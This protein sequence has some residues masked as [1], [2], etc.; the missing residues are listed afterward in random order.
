MSQ[1]NGVWWPSQGDSVSYGPLKITTTAVKDV[2][3]D[4]TEKTYDIAK[5]V[6]YND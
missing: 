4:I 5:R 2:G 6:R 1:E 3:R